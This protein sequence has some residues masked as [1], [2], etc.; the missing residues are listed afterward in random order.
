MLANAYAGTNAEGYIRE[1]PLRL[2]S[3]PALG[4]E[5]I[6]PRIPPRIAMQAVN[7]KP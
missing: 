2:F 6:R 3:K 5:L 1:R 7:A 4:P